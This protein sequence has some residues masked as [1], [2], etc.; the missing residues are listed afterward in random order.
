[1]KVMKNNGIFRQTHHCW[2]F[3]SVFRA[4]TP[5]EAEHDHA[6]DAERQ[7]QSE[8][9]AQVVDV[10]REPVHVVDYAKQLG[11]VVAQ[12]LIETDHHLVC[13]SAADVAYMHAN[14]LRKKFYIIYIVHRYEI[15]K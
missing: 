5:E 7:S 4:K 3:P 11:H 10:A 6:G 9:D 8:H 15:Y 14:T 2:Q 13:Q 1:M 12:H